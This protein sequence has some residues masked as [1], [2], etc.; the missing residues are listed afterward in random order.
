M[1]ASQRLIYLL[2]FLP[3]AQSF[4]AAQGVYPLWN[5]PVNIGKQSCRGTTIV[6]I[7][8]NSASGDDS[9]RRSVGDTVGYV[10]GG[11][12]QFGETFSAGQQFAASGV[13]PQIIPGQTPAGGTDQLPKWAESFVPRTDRLQGTVV[14]NT[15]R[16]SDGVRIVN[17]EISWEPFYARLVSGDGAAGAAAGLAAAGG[18]M[19]VELSPLQGTLAPRGGA[20]NA[21]DASKPYSDACTIFLHLRRDFKEEK[22]S[23]EPL[24]LVVKTEQRTWSWLVS[25]LPPVAQ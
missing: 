13:N 16:P 17:D 2:I 23:A 8:A 22:Q 12:Y 5:S 4:S 25:L 10:H 7:R 21:C 6:R 15:E 3:A 19:Q 18:G 24:Y 14:L 1:V 20:N 11:K 9:S